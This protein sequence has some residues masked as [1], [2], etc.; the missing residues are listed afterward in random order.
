MKYSVQWRRRLVLALIAFIIA[1]GLFLGF[2]PQPVEVDFATAHRAPL[3]V[4]IEQEGRT[5]VVDRY[6]VTA[7]V[8]GY[9][10]RI[11]LDVGNAVERG[12]TLAELEPVRAEVLDMRRRAEAEALRESPQKMRGYQQDE[13]SH[14]GVRVNF[15]KKLPVIPAKAGI[16]RSANRANAIWIPAFAGMTGKMGGKIELKN[17]PATTTKYCKDVAIG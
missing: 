4:T 8:N 9:A 3:R 1:G 14:A 2:R 6:I 10:R 17:P 11:A 12:A 5:R 13:F 7:P 16:H 15:L